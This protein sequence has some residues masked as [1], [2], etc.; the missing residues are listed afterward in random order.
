MS[1]MLNFVALLLPPA[2]CEV[3]L[4][5]LAEENAS[6]AN[7]LTAI[8]GYALRRQ[9]RH[10]RS[11]RPWFAAFALCLPASGMLLGSSVAFSQLFLAPTHASF[12]FAALQLLTI[13]WIVGYAAVALSRSTVWASLLVV[14]ITGMRCFSLFH[15]PGLTP[16]CLF[17]FAPALLFGLYIALRSKQLP[18]WITLLLAA[19]SAML[20][21]VEMPITGPRQTLHNL[22]LFWPC[23][24]IVWL[25]LSSTRRA[26]EAASL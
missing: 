16:F 20:L 22:L 15:V 14:G 1:R 11:W 2:D 25:A 23:W 10:W 19:P 3:V 21:L 4:G 9:L 13:A 17:L 5:D 26:K 6:L 12:T 7:A 18:F 24:Y 8:L